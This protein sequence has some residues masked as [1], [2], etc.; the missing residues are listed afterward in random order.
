MNVS[1]RV[2]MHFNRLIAAAEDGELDLVTSA[3]LGQPGLVDAEDELGATLLHR[4]A[5]FGR[6]SIVELLLRSGA[7]PNRKDRKRWT[8]LHNASTGYEQHIPCMCL[9]LR[10]GSTVEAR[11]TQLAT[12]LMICVEYSNL[13]GLALLLGCGARVDWQDKRG[14]DAL[15]IAE[16]VLERARGKSFVKQ[17]EDL[18]VMIEMIK[19]FMPRDPIV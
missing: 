16:H 5:Q 13:A 2:E 14:R 3:L 10:A 19:A 11:T 1:K 18:A 17:R 6:A 4:A 12:P 15:A 9:L 8:P 7:N